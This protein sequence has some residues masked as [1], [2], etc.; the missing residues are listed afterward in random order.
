MVRVLA[1]SGKN[2]VL[3]TPIHWE[4]KSPW[5]PRLVR[6]EEL[7]LREVGIENFRLISD[8]KEPFF[9]HKDDVHDSGWDQI[10]FHGVENGW[11]RNITHVSPSMAVGLSMSKHCVVYDCRII[12]NPGHNGFLIGR[13]SS[14]NLLMRLQGG[15]A[16]HTWSISGF[17]S[18]NVFHLC[19]SD[20]PSAIDCHG[21]LAIWN[22][23]DQ[24]Y[25]TVVANGGGPGALPPAHGRGLVL[26]DIQAGTLSPYNHRI[27]T[28]F[29]SM[30]NYPGLWVLG[31]RSQLGFG[32]EIVDGNGR[33]FTKDFSNG[34]GT[35]SGFNTPVALPFPSLYGHQR[36][37]RYGN[38][39][40][41]EPE[42]MKSSPKEA[43]SEAVEE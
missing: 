17:A 38:L 12:G 33:R 14:Q 35:V 10:K 26:Y 18:G 7:C 2:L 27:Q 22:L 28:R 13:G 24:M 5:K 16:M 30:R 23:F 6:I 32:L 8:F 1:V 21:T 34:W 3:E 43:A 39:L 42:L 41:E 19:M 15:G 9:H 29:L 37:K 25:G 4:L 20:Q 36:E 40:P 11:V 31:L